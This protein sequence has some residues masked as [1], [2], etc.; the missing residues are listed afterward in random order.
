[1]IVI[2]EGRL[3]KCVLC[4]PVHTEPLTNRASRSQFIPACYAFICLAEIYENE[5][6]NVDLCRMFITVQSSYCKMYIVS[7]HVQFAFRP[8]TE[9]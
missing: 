4:S 1:M 8:I 9:T 6:Q 7:S 2:N 5:I 3:F